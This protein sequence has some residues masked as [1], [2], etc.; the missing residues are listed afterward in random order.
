MQLIA[1][2]SVADIQAVVTLAD[3]IW[4]QHY[5]SIIGLAQIDYM[6]QTLQSPAAITQQLAQGYRYF[7]IARDAVPLGYIS[8]LSDSSSKTLY[9]SKFYIQQQ[10]RRQGVGRFA[11]MQLE[12]LAKQHGLEQIRLTVN[13]YNETAIAAYQKMGFVITDS[14]V[15]AISEGFVMDDYEMRKYASN[16]QI[17]P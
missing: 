2:K 12:K 4:H 5:L 15:N 13:K 8:V 10:E 9:L 17:F 7:F 11:L 16:S 6:L 3:E 1:V 14:I